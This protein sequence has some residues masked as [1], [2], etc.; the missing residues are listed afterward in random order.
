MTGMSPD[1]VIVTV[2][3]VLAGPILWTVWLFRMSRLQTHGRG[4]SVTPVSLALALCAGLLLYVLETGASFDVVDAPQYQFMY[5]VLGLAWL[6]VTASTFPFLG[7]SPRDD[8]IERGNSASATAVVGALGG[9]TLC[10]AGGNIGD[11]PGW[12]VVLFS[13]GLATGTLLVTW[14]A[15]ASLTPI[16]DA[17]TIDRDPAAGV[18][19][20]SFLAS[21][22]LILGRGVAGDWV[23]A[24]ATVIDFGEALSGVLVILV[25]AVIVER[26]ARLTHQ[27]PRAPLVALGVV[28]AVLY[29]AIATIAVRLMGWPV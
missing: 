18:R 1:E 23:S 28:P 22:G 7:L 12:W 11:G 3:A 14:A 6:R 2:V 4:G 17:S 13:A 9:V 20:G 15:L 24:T 21:C 10:Y 25:L 5:V 26:A 19:L 8:V 27:R 16:A 29:V